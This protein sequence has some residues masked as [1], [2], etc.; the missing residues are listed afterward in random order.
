MGVVLVV[1]AVILLLIFLFII[2]SLNQEIE[3]LGCY[4]NAD[5]QKIETSLSITHFAFGAFGF[6]FALGFYLLFFSK[7]K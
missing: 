2:R 4:P 7:G 1:L 6:L 3:A 5:C